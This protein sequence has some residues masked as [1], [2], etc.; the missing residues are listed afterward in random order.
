[1][2]KMD[3]VYY[4]KMWRYDL[5]LPKKKKKKQVPKYAVYYSK[6]WRYDLDLPKKKG[7]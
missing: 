2:A 3:A 7:Q 1:M 4:S 6:M 5:D